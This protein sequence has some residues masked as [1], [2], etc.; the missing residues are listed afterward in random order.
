MHGR[1]LLVTTFALSITASMAGAG[2]HEGQ[3]AA[4]PAGQAAA[5]V[6]QCA[7]AQPLVT[8]ALDA[9]LKRLE[10]AR[11]SNSPSALRTA[12]D[13]VESAL[14]DVRARLEP[15]AKLSAADDAHRGHTMPNVQQAPSAAP[16]TSA[17]YCRLR[18]TVRSAYTAGLCVT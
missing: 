7:Q 14:L 6:T 16:A 1:A 4:A 12:A 2:Q 13:D 18:R 11:L 5:E 10:D 9:A 15:C 3:Q 17:K 8:G